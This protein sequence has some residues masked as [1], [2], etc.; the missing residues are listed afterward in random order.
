[1][2]DIDIMMNLIAAV[3]NDGTVKD[4][5]DGDHDKKLQYDLLFEIRLLTGTPDSEYARFSVH[6][7]RLFNDANE[8]EVRER[9]RSYYAAYAGSGSIKSAMVAAL[10]N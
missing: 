7:E 10:D 9:L 5:L 4:P 6:G 1:M 8:D 2:Q 3:R